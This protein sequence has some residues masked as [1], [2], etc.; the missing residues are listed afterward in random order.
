MIRGD[1]ACTPFYEGPE[2]V[3]EQAISLAECADSPLDGFEW[4]P[5][6]DVVTLVDRCLDALGRVTVDEAAPVWNA[7]VEAAPEERT[8]WA[9]ALATG[10][11]REDALT[12][13]TTLLPTG[14]PA[15]GCALAVEL[16][17][18]DA[19]PFVA[20]ALAHHLE[21]KQF[22]ASS[23]P[24]DEG[25]T[26]LARLVAQL[27]DPDLEIRLITAV[28]VVQE[29]EDRA[30][31]TNQGWRHRRVTAVLRELA[32]ADPERA[33]AGRLDA[34]S[35]ALGDDR[36][37]LGGATEALALLPMKDVTARVPE[38]APMYA[39]P[40]AGALAGRDR[41]AEAL[42]LAATLPPSERQRALL[43]VARRAPAAA[44]RS[45]VAAAFK[46]CPK[47]DRSRDS[48]QMWKHRYAEVLL[49][50]DDVDGAIEVLAGMLDCRVSRYGPSPLIELIVHH[51]DSDPDRSA[52]R[53][54]PSRIQT[55]LD[56]LSGPNV[57]P[58]EV[59]GPL[60]ALVPSV[61]V[62]HRELWK[63]VEPRLRAK[64]HNDIDAAVV[65]AA[66]AAG[67]ARA[68]DPAEAARLLATAMAAV[69]HSPIYAQPTHFLWC[70][71]AGLI[72]NRDALWSQAFELAGLYHPRDAKRI[73][74]R[75]LTGL[76]PADAALAARTVDTSRLPDQV[77]D[78][79][80]E[81]L[82]ELVADRLD[83]TAI[84]P[85]EAATDPVT[86][87]RR[88]GQAA[89]HLARRGRHADALRLAT[90]CGLT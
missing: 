81:L 26:Y 36:W 2:L 80:R 60:L 20:A 69:T 89:R 7:A 31:S 57:I 88:V 14:L 59:S 33:A 75:I 54:T 86:V 8:A 44:D 24:I 79:A 9:R 25:A 28:A 72:A 50:D 53:W 41:V 87:R 64:L 63:A 85:V 58:S 17:H 61:V 11:R 12:V 70:V 37:L 23:G 47:A 77:L 27:D 13:L 82:G 49:A 90:A 6:I 16:L 29:Y 78:H 34:W 18:A 10:G 52:E 40:L 74:T 1:A 71:G 84:L 56:V 42:A 39:V 65:T 3:T 45:K 4:I 30:L 21:L 32:A 73:V 55:L 46:K 5:I 48:Q 22:F 66:W 62:H 67:L 83:D 43:A 38:L 51:L 15:S 76:D 19:G 35:A 68:G